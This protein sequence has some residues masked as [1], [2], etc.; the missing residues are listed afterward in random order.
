MCLCVRGSLP[1]VQEYGREQEQKVGLALTEGADRKGQLKPVGGFGQDQMEFLFEA[2]FANYVHICPTFHF[3]AS[4][5]IFGLA[6][7]D[8]ALYS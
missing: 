6:S 3:P 5:H 2:V 1:L 8:Y 7:A 4:F